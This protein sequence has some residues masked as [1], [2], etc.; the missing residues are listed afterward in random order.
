MLGV[1]Q[2]IMLLSVHAKDIYFKKITADKFVFEKIFT[3]CLLDRD[4]HFS[5]QRKKRGNCDKSEL[6]LIVTR[7]NLRR[8]GITNSFFLFFMIYN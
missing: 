1:S 8:F 4:C 6:R 7:S 3:I 2:I 5:C